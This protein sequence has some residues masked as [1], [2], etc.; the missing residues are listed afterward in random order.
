MYKKLNIKPFVSI[1]LQILLLLFVAGQVAKVF[2]TLDNPISWMM[3]ST[4]FIALQIMIFV[5]GFA[6]GL[7]AK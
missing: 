2:Y 3:M 1:T 6:L 5:G 4:M 7:K